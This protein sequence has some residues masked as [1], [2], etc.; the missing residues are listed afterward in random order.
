MRFSGVKSTST[1]EPLTGKVQELLRLAFLHELRKCQ[2][3]ETRYEVESC[4][5]RGQHVV[6]GIWNKLYALL[7][8]Y[9]QLAV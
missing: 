4:R 9:S 2:Q 3:S 7:G 5:Y 6:A 1:L 8:S